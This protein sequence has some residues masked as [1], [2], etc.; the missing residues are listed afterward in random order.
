MNGVPPRNNNAASYQPKTSFS[1][2]PSAEQKQSSALFGRSNSRGSSGPDSGSR[3]NPSAGSAYNPSAGASGAA[4]G[5]RNS[6][7]GSSI[8]SP[9]QSPGLMKPPSSGVPPKPKMAP[10]VATFQTKTFDYQDPNKNKKGPD[11]SM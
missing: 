11:F 3:Y 1:Y 2:V 6:N 5:R 9:V 10:P 7:S 4:M 8:M